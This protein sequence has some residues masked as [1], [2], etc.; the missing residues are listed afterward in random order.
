MYANVPRITF[1]RPSYAGLPA[2]WITMQY[3]GA[4]VQRWDLAGPIG[5][6]AADFDGEV[7]TRADHQRSTN[8]VMMPSGWDVG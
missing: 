3:L 2:P 5:T 8:R 1:K 6:E 7:F 4:A